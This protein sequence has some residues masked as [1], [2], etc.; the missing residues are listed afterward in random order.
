[1]FLTAGKVA[2][3]AS[4]SSQKEIHNSSYHFYFQWAGEVISFRDKTI[5]S[6]EFAELERDIE[7]RRDGATR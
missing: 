2:P 6:D 1:M 3:G 4:T 5:L 7:L